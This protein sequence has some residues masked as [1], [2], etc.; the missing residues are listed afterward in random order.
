MRA[1]ERMGFT[2]VS[3][4]SSHVKLRKQ[5]SDGTYTVIVPMHPELA[6]GTIGSIVRQ[7]GITREQL[8]EHL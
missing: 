3:Q 1:L 4:E 2:F 7:A 8:S 6:Q 5:V